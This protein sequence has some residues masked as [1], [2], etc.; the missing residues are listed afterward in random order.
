M[1]RL[2]ISTSLMMLAI[3]AGAQQENNFKVD[4]QLRTRG[5]YNNGA[6]YPR[7]EGQLPATF[8]SERARI[9]VDFERGPLEMKL[10]AQ[11]TGL[12]G[13]DGMNTSN[14]RLTMNQAWAKLKFA[15]GWFAQIGRQQLSYDDERILGTGDWNMNG[16]WHDA[17]K[18]GYEKGTNKVHAFVAMNQNNANRGNYYQG[19]MPYKA[20][21]GVWFNHQW[22]S[23]PLNISLLGLNTG[24]ELGKPGNG[25]T[26]YMQTI[27]TDVN[28]K[29]G[30]WNLH[31]AFYYQMGTNAD[32]LKV[33]SCMA[34]FKVGYQID[35]KW[36]VALG[37][38][39]LEGENYIG[40]SYNN[41]ELIS[42]TKEHYDRT[43]T[44][45][46][47][48]GSHHLFYGM[49]DYFYASDFVGGI[50]PGLGDLQVDVDYKAS[51]KTS[52]KMNY[53]YFTTA[54]DCLDERGLG[55]E[56]DL[57]FTTKLMKDVTLMGGYSV[58]RGTK[59][60]DNVKGGDHSSWQDWAWISLNINM[61]GF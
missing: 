30:A 60:M 54:S 17:L 13:Q 3:A 41:G 9:S 51:T 23:T 36:K 29:P 22:Q 5:E 19:S 42:L 49:M 4:A 10:S 56:V 18:V 46:P 35:E 34:S 43:R 32:N 50:E 48:Y 2:I 45:N 21:Q 25:K 59:M 58:M 31:G 8:I 12:W 14:G 28:Y 44:F 61:R 11:H 38:D 7:G 40:A 52:L 47:L 33:S 39:Y 55:H 37:M 24:Y 15:D 16:N 53:H 20:M 6:V 27:G 57:Q 1:K 26:R